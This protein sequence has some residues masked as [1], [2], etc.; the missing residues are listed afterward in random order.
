MSAFSHNPKAHIITNESIDTIPNLRALLNQILAD[1]DGDIAIADVDGLLTALALKA[2]LASP[3]FTGTVDLPATTN[4]EFNNVALS[5]MFD[6]KL[7]AA[8]GF[9]A[10]TANTTAINLAS[11]AGKQ[12]VTITFDD[13]LNKTITLNNDLKTGREYLIELINS[14]STTSILNTFPIPC[15]TDSDGKVNVPNLTRVYLSFFWHNLEEVWVLNWGG[16]MVKKV[17]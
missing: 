7:D 5:T 9:T 4:V 15:I 13:G 3:A 12:V 10:L 8:I 11:F 1:L 16:A 6:A 17:S 14:H 2:P